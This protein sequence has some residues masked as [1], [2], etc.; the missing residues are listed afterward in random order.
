[1]AVGSAQP[2]EQAVA[3][4]PK[5]GLYSARQQEDRGHQAAWRPTRMLGAFGILTRSQCWAYLLWVTAMG[6]CSVMFFQIV[7]HVH[8]TDRT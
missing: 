3:M 6:S 5:Q 7:L 8:S 2:W 4:P 1:M